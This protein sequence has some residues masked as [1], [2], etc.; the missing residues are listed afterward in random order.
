MVV[1]ALSL[2]SVL[3]M[4]LIKNKI[5]KRVSLCIVS[6]TALYLAAMGFYIAL[7]GF[8]GQA[9]IAVLVGAAAVGAIILDIIGA[10]KGIDSLGLASRICAAA[11]LIIGFINAIS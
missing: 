7:Y 4:F 11:A 9:V 1:A 10:K 3:L 8:I 2:L 6:A 5:V